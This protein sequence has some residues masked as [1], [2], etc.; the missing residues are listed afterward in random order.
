MAN[1]SL[2]ILN[3][4]PVEFQSVLLLVIGDL[5]LL[6]FLISI[7]LQENREYFG[8]LL[9]KLGINAEPSDRIGRH[10][11]LTGRKLLALVLVL[12]LVTTLL[13]AIMS[14]IQKCPTSS[15]SKS[16]STHVSPFIRM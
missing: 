1:L 13:Y 2:K 8:G 3:C 9:K 6:A 11:T 16:C 4:W 14:Y 12:G 15:T 7:T 10:L 5:L